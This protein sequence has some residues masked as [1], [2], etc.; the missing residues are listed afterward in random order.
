MDFTITIDGVTKSYSKKVKLLD[1]TNNNKDI[2]CANVNGRIRE[3]DYDV[4]YDSNIS[5]LTLKDHDA[6]GIYEK[7]IRYL[8][9]M[10]SNIEY[11]GIKFKMTYSVSRSIYAQLISSDDNN[12]SLFVTPKMAKRIEDRMNKL[13]SE[14]IKF[15]RLIKSNDEARKIYNDFKLYDKEAILKYRPEKTVHFYKCGDY[16]NYMYGRMVPS[17]GYLKN[18]KLLY[19]TPGILIQYPRSEYNGE[20]PPFKDEPTFS[21]TLINAQKWSTLVKLDTVSNINAKIDQ[22]D[23]HSIVDLINICEDKHNRMLCELGQKIEDQIETIRLICIA[24][25]SSSGKTTFADRLTVELKSRGINPIRISLDDYY[26]KREDVPLDEDGN[27]DFESIDAL[28]VELFNENILDLLNGQEVCLPT[29]SFKNNDSTFDRRVK[30]G[31]EDPIIIEGIHALN[32]QMTTS[33]PKYLK[34]KIYISPQAQINLDNENPISLSDIRLI[35]RIVRDNQYRGSSAE[36]T[37]KMWPSVR[38]GE[39]KWIYATQEYANYVFDSFLNYE[40][41][42]LARHA[43]PLLKSIDKESEFGPDAERLIGLLKYFSPINEKWIPCSSI[44]KEFTGGSCY[45][46]A[47]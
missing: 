44:L 15:E 11:P 28:D 40:L 25:P 8:F 24:G 14:D 36:E 34:F 18:F 20:I 6:M 1:L 22:D 26:K 46:D 3:L 33:I 37:L 13:V 12:R 5:F 30:I 39:F 31:P 27:Y 29:F 38:K 10:A 41:C 19:Y 16:F 4:Y 47:K 21:D 32:E 45:R 23:E 7:G 35:R 2:I 43:L 17:T 42:V 9:A